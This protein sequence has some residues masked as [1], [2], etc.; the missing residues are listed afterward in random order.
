MGSLYWQLNDVWPGAS[1]SGI[2][3]Y[4]RWKALHYHARRFFA[5]VTVAALRKDGAT[6]VTLVS[7]RTEPRAGRLHQ[8]VLAL[9]GR[10]LRE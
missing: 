5:P 9:D 2:D 3:W 10:L 1:W 6:R 7:D 8:R 4:G